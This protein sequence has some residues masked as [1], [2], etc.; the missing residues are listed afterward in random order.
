MANLRTALQSTAQAWQTNLR[1]LFE[2]GQFILGRQVEVFEQELAA[3]F[4]AKFAVA[5]GSGTAAIELC[6]RAAG[7]GES[8][9]E[10]IVPALTSPFT[11]QAV[12]AAGC[13][14]RF[15]DVDCE[16]LLLDASDAAARVGK[17]T[18]AVLPVLL[19]GQPCDLRA[20]AA[21]GVPVVQDACQAHGGADFSRAS[22][23]A[24]FSFYPTKNLPCLG[25]GGAVVTNSRRLAERVRLLRNG[26]RRGGQVAQLR[27]INARLD[28]MQACYLRAFL[29][30]LA[31]WNA[32]RSRLASLYDEVLADCAG[33]KAVA[34]RPGSV[35]HLYVVRAR[36]RD[37]LRRFLAERGIGSGV[38]YPVALHLQPAFCHCGQ[39]RGSLPV[40]ERACREIVSLPL[41]PG[42]GDGA[43][44]EV[45]GAVRQFY[46][47]PST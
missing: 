22:S 11:A 18:R 21:M 24:A 41:W 38:H 39:R 14:P 20:L 8:G 2:T 19:Y 44:E 31:E 28:E 32:E 12:L 25:D 33:V 37:G 23:L 17:N 45:A 13:R 16:H 10:V 29:P 15:A 46:R 7:L 9:A 1:C 40:A 27:A 6:L 30:K 43:V 42:M 35:C 5:V 34:R 36:R 3:A 47:R 4:G 26:G